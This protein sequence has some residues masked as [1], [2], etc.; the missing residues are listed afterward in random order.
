M[1]PKQFEEITLRIPK[2]L[3]RKPEQLKVAS[4]NDYIIESLE[5]MLEIDN[6][7]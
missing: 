6:Q 5:I 3:M 1:E 4:I 2:R 7:K